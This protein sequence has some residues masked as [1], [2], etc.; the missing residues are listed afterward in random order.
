MTTCFKK[1][2]SKNQ[3]FEKDNEEIMKGKIILLFLNYHY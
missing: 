3:N 1:I 2:K